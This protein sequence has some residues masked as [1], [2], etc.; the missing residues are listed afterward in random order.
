MKIWKRWKKFSIEL[1]KFK[2]IGGL[3]LLGIVKHGGKGYIEYP[4]YDYEEIYW[5]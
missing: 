3:L 5:M 2:I 1:I 4:D